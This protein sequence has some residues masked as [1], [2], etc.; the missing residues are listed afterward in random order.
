MKDENLHIDGSIK[1]EEKLPKLHVLAYF[2]PNL[3]SLYNLGLE[4]E[5]MKNVIMDPMKTI[6]K[7]K[8]IFINSREKLRN[9]ILALLGGDE[10]ASEYI[11]FNLLSRVH[12]R[13]DPLAL[14]NFPINLSN[15][16][17]S[18]V[19]P[20][21]PTNEFVQSFSRFIGT[22]T[23]RS[24]NIELSIPF[25][26]KTELIPK[27]NYD[28]NEIENSFLQLVD[29]TYLI[30][31]ETS[32]GTGKLSAQGF[33]NLRTLQNIITSQQI[34]YDFTYQTVDFPT[35]YPCIILSEAKSLFKETTEI[36]LCPKYASDY[37]I[38]A[39]VT[40]EIW[41]DIVAF[42][43][44]LTDSRIN[45]ALDPTVSEKMQLDFVEAR[46]KDQEECEK[47][48]KNRQITPGTFHHWICL[49]RLH[50]ISYGKTEISI[51]DYY[52]VRKLETE[53]LSRLQK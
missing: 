4:N 10:M 22:F 29:Q 20:A 1:D 24:K 32:M 47:S 43:A 8:E 39:K 15:T 46:R 35:N 17:I 37:G 16:P 23:E 6:G 25:L 2:K 5:L 53:R 48:G 50:A 52:A 30:I 3:M 34:S 51:E 28:T 14:G 9:V 33:K 31:N 36:K 18:P 49:T 45:V 7:M 41:R 11:I 12:S 13:K 19:K 44:I 27:K 21:P 38:F 42:L 40:K 26:E